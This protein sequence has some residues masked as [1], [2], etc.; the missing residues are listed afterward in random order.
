M[1]AF[2]SGLIELAEACCATRGEDLPAPVRARAIGILADDVGAILSAAKEPEIEA[3]HAA[4]LRRGSRPEATVYLPGLHRVS[5]EDALYLNAM[6]GC[7]CETDEGYRPVTCHAGLYVLPALLAEAERADL[8]LDDVIRCLVLGYEICARLAEC[9]R[10]PTPRV[11]AHAL[12]APV[13]AAA[14][15]L[16]ARNA[17]A[18]TL[19][20]G[21]ATA[22]TLASIG[23]RTHLARG[24]LSRNLWAATGA[25]AG[26]QAA[27]MAQIGIHAGT[28]APMD[29]Y[30]EILG[31][32]GHVS[33]LTDGL[34][35]GWAVSKGYHKLYACCQHG[36]SAVE[37]ALDC[38]S[39][40][41]YDADR[42]HRIEVETHP[43]AIGLSNRSP[44]TILGA[45]FSMEHMVAA[46]LRY[47]HGGQA[48]FSSVA[49]DDP[50]VARL[51]T[52]VRLGP[53]TPPADPRFDRASRV[54]VHLADGEALDRTCLVATG[55]PDRPLT[56]TAFLDKLREAGGD[57]LPGL[58]SFVETSARG[59]GELAWRDVVETMRGEP[60]Q[61]AAV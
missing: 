12:F 11:H 23:P 16:L 49:L 61:R 19:A 42:I 53:M 13:G 47:G 4:A 36:H 15:T 52:L 8:R 35:E 41:A 54:V 39:D 28:E 24:Y 20:R 14:A 26:W 29:V 1:D 33:A 45:K 59:L 25:V 5:F 40:P 37:A 43:L 27:G 10:F 51:R 6:A 22:A 31:G 32:A 60:A 44:E 34:H 56:D 46:P 55:S 50:I 7:W 3:A 21:I 17:P 57:V 2:S 48:A 30:G 18:P 9:F 58:A 38:V